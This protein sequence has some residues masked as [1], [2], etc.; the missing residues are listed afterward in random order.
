MV[1]VIG[2]NPGA[3]D[4]RVVNGNGQ[5]VPASTVVMIPD[6]GL[7]FRVD[8]KVAFTDASGAFQ[9]QGVPPG[10]YQVYAFE[11]IEKGD[12]QNPITMRPFE[13]RGKAL[14]INEGGKGT[15]DLVAI[16]GN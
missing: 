10:D 9:I 14:H 2:T 7:K 16:A 8:H 4:G 13:G 1:I 11:Q 6:S 3:L 12:W 15:I 5:P